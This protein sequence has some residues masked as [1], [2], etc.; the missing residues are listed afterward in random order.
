MLF[1]SR[2]LPTQ[3][4]DYSKYDTDHLKMLLRP[5]ILHRNEARF[6]AL[7]RKELK[8]REQQGVAEAEIPQDQRGPKPSEIPAYMRKAAGKDFPADLEKEKLRNISSKEWLAKSKEEVEEGTYTPTPKSGYGQNPEARKANPLDPINRRGAMPAHLGKDSPLKPKHEK[9]SQEKLKG[10]IKG[11]LG[12]HTTPNL[13]EGQGVAED[14]GPEQIAVGQLGPTEKVKKNSGA[15]GKLVG[16]SENFINSTA[17]AVVTE[18]DKTQTPPGRDGSRDEDAWKEGGKSTPIKPKDFAKFAT[19]QL[20]K[21]L[22]KH[23]KKKEVKEGQ[24]DLDA[25]LRIIRK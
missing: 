9:S 12:K 11:Q 19:K 3:G 5:G 2:Q 16:A 4:A 6:K 7:I 23:D 14:I 10:Q 18:M 13:P 21:M 22:T 15:R 1:R 25:M 8:K 24:D 17:Q 20:N